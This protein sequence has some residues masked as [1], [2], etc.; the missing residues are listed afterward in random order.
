MTVAGV[1]CDENEEVCE[2]FE[3]YGYPAIFV[4]PA[5]IDSEYLKYTGDFRMGKIAS[6]A[7]R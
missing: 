4:A 6:F 3:A 5:K 1:D 7:V 2:E